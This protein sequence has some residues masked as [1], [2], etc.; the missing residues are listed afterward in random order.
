MATKPNNL[1]VYL[2]ALDN[3]ASLNDV[4]GTVGVLTRFDHVVLAPATWGDANS[5]ALLERVL[6]SCKAVKPGMHFHGYT[7]YGVD[8]STLAA[9]IASWTGATHIAPHLSTIAVDNFNAASRTDQNA[10]VTSTHAADLGLTIM[11]VP[12]TEYEVLEQAATEAAP[13]LGGDATLRDYLLMS[14]LVRTHVDLPSAALE[15]EPVTVGRM[16]FAEGKQILSATPPVT[17]KNFG[18]LALMGAGQASTVNESEWKTFLN[19]AGLYAVEAY[20]VANF[21]RGQTSLR[22]FL[23]HR[24]NVFRS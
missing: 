11:V 10:L 15:P 13:L 23:D 3:I 2:G 14:G 20:G 22:Y 7:D 8:G 21:D 5:E 16:A 6:D 19:K 12:G 18:L 1:L 9:Q 4:N 17:F 24:G